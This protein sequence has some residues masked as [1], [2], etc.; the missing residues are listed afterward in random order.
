M[1]TDVKA[2]FPSLKDVECARMVRYAMLESSIKFENVDYTKALRYLR[3]VGGKD[4]MVDNGMGGIMPV[5]RGKKGWMI[6]VGGE[7]SREEI[8]WR[9][10]RREFRVRG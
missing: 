9:D 7:K 1:G 3:I 8:M 10:V 6:T 4:Y 5:W 2:L